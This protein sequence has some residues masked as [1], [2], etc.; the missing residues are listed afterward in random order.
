MEQSYEK[1]SE[2]P[3][4]S[5]KK[6]IWD[7]SAVEPA[8]EGDDRLWNE[9]PEGGTVAHTLTDVGAGDIEQGSSGKGDACGE[10]VR[11]DIASMTGID[12]NLMVT[13]NVGTTVPLGKAQPVVGTYQKD[14]GMLGVVTMQ[15]LQGVPRIA[16]TG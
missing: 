15:V 7:L 13:E 16:G 2:P 12:H 5:D 11:K 9:R 14:E 8:Y 1:E 6:L 10:A 3:S 4:D